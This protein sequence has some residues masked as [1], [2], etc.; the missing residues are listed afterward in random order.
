MAIPQLKKG[1]R[2]KVSCPS[3]L[4]YGGAHTWA[5]VGGEPIPLHSDIDFE[6]EVEDCNRTPKVED[7]ETQP[8]T[9][10]M[11]PERC[12]Y[13]HLVEAEDTA[14]DL[15]LSTEEED[16]S[17]WWPAKYVML[18]QKVVDDSA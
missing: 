3:Y 15:V 6:L 11:Q 10:T 2:A 7:E 8:V 9:T 12:M 16:F 5:P 4:V 18:E 14:Y 17:D 13:L 1:T